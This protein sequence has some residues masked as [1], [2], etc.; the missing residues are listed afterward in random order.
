MTKLLR[1]GLAAV[2]VAALA[3]PAN[4]WTC[5]PHVYF[6]KQTVAGHEVLVPSGY[7]MIC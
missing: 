2:A 7:E 1:F 6:D 5:S 3:A 4:A